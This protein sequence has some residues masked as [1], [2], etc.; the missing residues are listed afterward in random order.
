[1]PALRL[2]AVLPALALLG[3]VSAVRAGDAAQPPPALASPII[4]H[5]ALSALYLWGQVDTSGRIDA[6]TGAAGTSLDAERDLGVTRRAYQPRIELMFRLEERNRL[7]VDFFD[8]R[9]NGAQPLARTLQIGDQTFAA[10]QTV[11]STLE[12]RQ[13]DLTYSY[14]LLRSARYELGA[15]L[16]VHLLEARAIAQLPGTPQ[17]ADY[18]QAGPFATLALDGTWL[19]A[20]RW[21]LGARA[22]YLRLNVNSFS[23]LLEQFHADMQYRWRPNLAFGVSY[24][25]SVD[26]VDVRHRDPSGILRLR[27][28]GP[29]LFVRVSY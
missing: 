11:Q 27:I 8:L 13:M 5:F 3:A 10:G 2:R 18:S 29:E 17:R 24:D 20:Q 12:W 7:R 9:R 28:V 14:S 6:G 21:A 25:Y 22:Q 16:G 26:Q 23:G 15:G 1:M 4:D 19:L